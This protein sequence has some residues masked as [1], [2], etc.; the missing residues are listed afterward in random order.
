MSGDGRALQDD[1]SATK[2]EG[3]KDKNDEI[4]ERG[5]VGHGWVRFAYGP[6]CGRK[7]DAAGEQRKE[8]AK[9]DRKPIVVIACALPFVGIGG[10]GKEAA[11][12][13]A[14]A[15]SACKRPI[16]KGALAEP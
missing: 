7:G 4:K 11:E 6:V 3:S 16:P 10:E 8:Q 14:H 12:L 9:S 15:E 2:A 1:K 5:E 13:E